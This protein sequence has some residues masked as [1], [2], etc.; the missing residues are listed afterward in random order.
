MKFRGPM[1]GLSVFMVIALAMTWLVYATLRREVAGSTK[2]YSAMFT[3]A[4]GLRDGDDVRVAGV[5]V[6]RVESVAIDGDLAKVDFRVQDEQPLYGNTIAT[7]TYQ[8]IVGQRYLGLSLG[9]TGS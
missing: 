5:R 3:D 4:T 9:K 1:V 8:N 2:D 6:G 7:I